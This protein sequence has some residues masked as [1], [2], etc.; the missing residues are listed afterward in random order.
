MNNYEFEVPYY[1]FQEI[2]EYIEL[3]AGGKNKGARWDNIKA[4]IGL[5]VI[6]KRITRAQGDF[7]I[8]TY[9]RE[10]L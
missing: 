6:N 7:L 2:V 10:K 3:S 5:A 4:L 8:K 9:C 1:I